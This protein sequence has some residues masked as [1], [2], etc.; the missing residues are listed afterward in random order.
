[1]HLHGLTAIEQSP[2]YLYFSKQALH[3]TFRFFKK[4]FFYR[5]D[6]KS[7]ALQPPL[8]P[9]EVDFGRDASAE[10]FCE[11]EVMLWIPLDCKSAQYSHPALSNRL[12]IEQQH[13]LISEVAER[14]TFLK[15]ALKQLYKPKFYVDGIGD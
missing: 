15:A 11:G 5:L 2:L 9:C 8:P 6:C 10:D 1:M 13:Y 3:I 12:F 4:L 7:L 14:Y